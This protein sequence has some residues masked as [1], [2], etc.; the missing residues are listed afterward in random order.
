MAENLR[1]TTKIAIFATAYITLIIL[2]ALFWPTLYRYEKLKNGEATIMIRLNRITGYTEILYPSV[3][4][5][6]LRKVKEI[7][8]MPQEEVKKITIKRNFFV[9]ESD[10]G[11]AVYNGTPWF[12]KKIRLS[13]TLKHKDKLG[14]LQEGIYEIPIEIPPFST[15]DSCI[16]KHIQLPIPMSELGGHFKEVPPPPLTWQPPA[17]EGPYTIGIEKV[18]GYKGD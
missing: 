10:Y 16:I 8:V 13:L 6:P 1:E 3:G 15:N 14:S 18:L 7:Q 4:W 12:V 17:T 9:S 2:G 5:E 11:V